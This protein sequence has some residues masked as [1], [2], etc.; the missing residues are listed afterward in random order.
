MNQKD[1]ERQLKALDEAKITIQ[2]LW[3][4]LR[5][6]D[7]LVDEL[8]DEVYRLKNPKNNVGKTA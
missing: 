7:R 2:A 3:D 4:K 5:A 8:E 6:R 1:I